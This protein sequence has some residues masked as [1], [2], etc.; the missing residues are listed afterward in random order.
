MAT[1]L[2]KG[3]IRTRKV[4]LLVA[5]GID[6]T[7]LSAVQQ[8]LT[9]P[10]AVALYVGPRLG[11]IK[12]VQGTLDAAAST[13]NM[14]PVL[15]DGLVIPDGGVEALAADDH[16]ME[17]VQSQYRHGKTIL[18]LG[19]GRQFLEQAGVVAPDEKSERAGIVVA[20]SAQIHTATEA[21]ITALTQH[22]HPLRQTETAPV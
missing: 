12:T 9:A 13:E 1:L 10:G 19:T 5:S 16:V 14:P 22:R 15:F 6:A 2:G 17:F 7:S 3:G 20:K 18:A 21:F 11:T 4:A 8:A